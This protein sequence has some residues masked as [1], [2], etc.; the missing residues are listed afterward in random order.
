MEAFTERKAATLAALGTFVTHASPC[1]QQN[2]EGQA[3]FRPSAANSSESVNASPE[4]LQ[5]IG[6]KLPVETD[7]L[8]GVCAEVSLETVTKW[9]G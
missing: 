4:P 1:S 6:A 8:K 5:S 2:W 9:H 3:Q 7:D